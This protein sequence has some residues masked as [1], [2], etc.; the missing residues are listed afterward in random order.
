MGNIAETF[1]NLHLEHECTAFC[2]Q[3][4][5]ERPA[6]PDQKDTNPPINLKKGKG[7]SIQPQTLGSDVESEQEDSDGEE[8]E[9][10]DEDQVEH[11]QGN[12]IRHLSIT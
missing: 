1:C 2:C 10:A 9:V 5:L 3:F 7:K 4:T 12:V 6:A 8:K 11:G